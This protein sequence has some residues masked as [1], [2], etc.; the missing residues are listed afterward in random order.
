MQ[1]SVIIVK[2]TLPTAISNSEASVFPFLLTAGPHKWSNNVTVVSSGRLS[3]W[4]LIPHSQEPLHVKAVGNSLAAAHCPFARHPGFQFSP[5]IC[6]SYRGEN[7]VLNQRKGE[8]KR[9][10]SFSLGSALISGAT[11]SEPGSLPPLGSYSCSKSN[12]SMALGSLSRAISGHPGTGID[13]HSSRIHP[14][15]SAVW[16]DPELIYLGQGYSILIELCMYW[17]LITHFLAPEN[18]TKIDSI[19]LTRSIR[20][21]RWGGGERLS[22]QEKEKSDIRISI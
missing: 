20:E 13:W 15:L 16:N 21:R 3:S 1:I 4:R 5:N 18:W 19:Y 17:G 7:D 14:L 10:S 11:C 22:H 12:Q 8:S 9:L 2:F 6:S